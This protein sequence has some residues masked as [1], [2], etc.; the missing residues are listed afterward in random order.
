MESRG[1]FCC[2]IL[3]AFVVTFIAGVGRL[4]VQRIQIRIELVYGWTRRISIVMDYS[5]VVLS[6][7]A[8]LSHGGGIGEFTS[9]LFVY[10]NR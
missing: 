4:S 5:P 8:G 2:D 6:R 1:L 10:I 3:P 9:E 7:V